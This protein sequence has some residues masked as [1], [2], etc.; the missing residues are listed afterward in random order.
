MFTIA[1]AVFIG[2]YY[3][4][5]KMLT[6]EG[7]GLGSGVRLRLRLRLLLDCNSLPLEDLPLVLQPWV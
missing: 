2:E 3:M 1:V 7:I 6:P 5:M 4:V